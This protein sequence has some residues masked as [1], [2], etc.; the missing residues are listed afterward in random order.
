MSDMKKA[1]AVAA[2][3]VRQRLASNVLKPVSIK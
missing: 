1:Y 2:I 3:A